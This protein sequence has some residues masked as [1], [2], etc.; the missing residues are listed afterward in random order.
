MPLSTCIQ[1]IDYSVPVATRQRRA[2]LSLLRHADLR[3]IQWGRWARSE[4]DY[5]GYPR[6]SLIYKILRRRS[7]RLGVLQKKPYSGLT[8]RGCETR[9]LR[10]RSVGAIDPLI[11]QVDRVVAS[12]DLPHRTVLRIEYEY[13]VSEQS[14]EVKATLLGVC[15]REYRCRLKAATLLVGRLLAA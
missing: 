3:L 8:A 5:L 10:P 12:L 15:A 2:N 7:K 6:L 14:V 9:S 11:D 4:A 13:T 1:D